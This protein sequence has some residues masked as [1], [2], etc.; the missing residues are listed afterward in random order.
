MWLFEGVALN[1]PYIMKWNRVCDSLLNLWVLSSDYISEYFIHIFT[2]LSHWTLL[3]RYTLIKL[4]DIS[5]F[6]NRYVHSAI[7]W[8]YTGLNEKWFGF[9][10][11]QTEFTLSCTD[12]LPSCTDS[13]TAAPIH[14][15]LHRFTPQLNRFTHSWTDSLPAAPIHSRLNRFTPAALILFFIFTLYFPYVT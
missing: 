7:S 3:T 1:Q 9:S 8:L 6:A 15:Q 12:S 10:D 2:G 4:V 11:R 14:S 13:P 5:F